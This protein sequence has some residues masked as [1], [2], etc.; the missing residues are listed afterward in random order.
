MVSFS[1]PK[2]EKGKVFQAPQ[3]ATNVRVFQ[4]YRWN[5]EVD[6]NP[7]Y[8]TFE[9]DMDKCGVMILDVLMKIKNEID[10]TLVFRRSCREGVCGSCAFNINGKNTLACIRQVNEF[11]GIIRI[12]PLPHRPVIKDLVIDLNTHYAQYKSIKPWLVSNT[13]VENKKE[14]LQSQEERAK[15]DGLW[16]CVLCF[17]CS[18]SCPSYWWN[19]ERGYLGPAIL[20]QAHR[21]I[22]DSRDENFGERLE[23]LDDEHKLYY[24]HTI[25]NCSATC[26]KGL[27]PAKS[28][29]DIK[30]KIAF[31]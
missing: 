26:P 12:F 1:V 23:E 11:K 13:P 15:L 22:E 24:C 27:N 10:T 17:C 6:E 30:K 2:L 28:I 21:W 20:L 29:A 31:K 25:M 4:I 14:R 19:G 7:R 5:P 18:S 3:G 8:D 9:I 16:E